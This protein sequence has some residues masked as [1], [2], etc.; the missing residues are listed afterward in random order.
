MRQIL[1]TL[2]RVGGRTSEIFLMHRME[3]FSHSEIAGKFGIIK[4]AIEKHIALAELALKTFL[5]REDLQKI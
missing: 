4:S 1:R 5:Q 3:G 2:D